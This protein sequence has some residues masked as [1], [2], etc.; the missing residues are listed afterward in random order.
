MPRRAKCG[1]RS[2]ACGRTMNAL[3]FPIFS[4]RFTAPDD[5]RQTLM[6]RS[7]SS[8]MRRARSNQRECGK[9]ARLGSSRVW[10]LYDATVAPIF[11]SADDKAMNVYYVVHVQLWQLA[12]SRLTG[13]V[14]LSLRRCDMRRLRQS[15]V[16]GD[17]IAGLPTMRAATGIIAQQGTEEGE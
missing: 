1:A 2:I 13:I 9:S 16:R 4:E 17:C 14:K 8:E 6:G 5:A 11:V 7:G 15:A 3:A 10:R 12:A